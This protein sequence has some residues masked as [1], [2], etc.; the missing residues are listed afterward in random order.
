MAKKSQK[1]STSSKSD[2]GTKSRQLS[3][4][5]LLNSMKNELL[6]SL[7]ILNEED[8][9]ELAVK[10]LE[11]GYRIVSTDS[12]ADGD[13]EGTWISEARLTH[14]IRRILYQDTK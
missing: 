11:R 10:V 6:P 2:T 9:Q 3:N 8:G 1:K 14:S 4:I 5:E 7:Y 12:Y 13:R